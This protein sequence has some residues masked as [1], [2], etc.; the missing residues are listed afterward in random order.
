ML[1]SLRKGTGGLVLWNFEMDAV[2]H[3]ISDNFYCIMYYVHYPKFKASYRVLL[4]Q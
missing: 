4:T 3:D 2:T 1:F